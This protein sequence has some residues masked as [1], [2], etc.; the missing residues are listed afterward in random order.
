M[1]KPAYTN[2]RLIIGAYPTKAAPALFRTLTNTQAD[3]AHLEKHLDELAECS[4]IC[5]WSLTGL[6]LQGASIDEFDMRAIAAAGFTVKDTGGGVSVENIHA[7]EHERL[8][9]AVRLVPGM[10]RGGELC[11]IDVEAT[12]SNSIEAAEGLQFAARLHLAGIGAKE[13]KGRRF[14]AF[15]AFELSEGKAVAT[16]AFPSFYD[17]CIDELCSANNEGI[18]LSRQPDGSVTI[19]CPREA[20]EDHTRALPAKLLALLANASIASPY[21]ARELRMGGWA[22]SRNASAER[23]ILGEYAAALADDKITACPH[24]GHPVFL[25]HKSSKPFHSASCQTRYRD[26]AMLY[27]GQ[28]ASVED[29]CG[30]FPHISKKTIANWQRE[31][32]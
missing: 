16:A 28:G 1:R 23:T 26:A 19:T 15:D 10:R 9:P 30:R 4:P 14:G 29:V 31:G 25:P 18:A 24:C 27:F 12:L 7:F 32:E 8:G 5:R 11:L 13:E 20:G 17:D 21:E 3:R 2:N 6:F 22:I